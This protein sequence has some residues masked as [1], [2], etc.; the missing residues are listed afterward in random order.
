MD[1]RFVALK[2]KTGV[3]KS[4]T[5]SREKLKLPQMN[6]IYSIVL[7][8]MLLFLMAPK[9]WAAD[10]TVSISSTD[11][12]SGYIQPLKS[13]ASIQ[14]QINVKNIWTGNCN[15]GINKNN[16][17]IPAAWVAID[18]NNQ[19]ITPQ[20]SVNFLIT[21]TIPANTSEGEYSMP[22]SFNAYDSSNYNHSF[23]YTTQVV[24]VDN[25]VP[26]LPT[27]SAIPS[28]GKIYVSGWSSYDA[29]SNTYT[30]KKPSSGISGIKSYTVTLKNPDNSVK[31]TQTINATSN[32]YYTFQNL[33][34]NVNYKVS[35]TATDIA[36]NTNAKEIVVAT[37]PAAPTMSSSVQGFC[38]ITLN[39]TASSGATS[40]KL[41]DATPSTPV[42]IT[43]TTN[44][45]YVVNGLT[46]ATVYKFYVVAY[47]SSG[48]GSDAGNTLSVSTLTVPVPTISGSQSICSSGT[49]LT[50]TNVPSGCS[51]EWV[52]GPG[53]SL[54]SSSGSSATFKA[55]DNVPSWI[56]ATINSGCGV[57]S[58]TYAVDAGKPKPGAISIDF[59]APPS[60]FT[61][62]IDGMISATSYN[63][64]LD[65]VL[66]RNTTSTLQVF[67]RQ[68]D[69]CG[70]VYYVDVEMVNGCGTSEL[71]HAEVSED[72][73][74]YYMVYPN[75]AVS[76]ISIT[77]SPEITSLS[78]A[79]TSPKP[80]N[81]KSIKIIDNNGITYMNKVYG[82]EIPNAS[83]N[84]SALKIGTY[85]IIINEG[86]G[87]E[88][89][90]FIKN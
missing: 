61:A 1:I 16:M 82:K 9:V 17:G 50:V 39:W 42:L 20:Q 65:G 41:Y 49:M 60:R 33:T 56:K 54:Y 21:L 25:S 4:V 31:E 83:L 38:N 28:S 80:R 46:S 67:N 69:N 24:T 81:I 35:V 76:E 89:H 68:L 47:N 43:T 79:A 13:G 77:Q 10:F 18:N 34:G 8:T 19:T 14:F 3:P 52:P 90:S 27:F 2:N 30:T 51:L 57:A 40:Y 5:Q 12:C 26:Q 58:Y 23:T 63:W 73:C 55:T 74:Y 48:L 71:R 87:Q 44:P 85:Q 59:D 22:L 7:T 15:V 62:S 37:A 45:S 53:L 32:N 86:K 84:I 64:Y 88:S 70:H 6:K 11:G 72:P 29:M 66:I 75:P 36:G 78:L